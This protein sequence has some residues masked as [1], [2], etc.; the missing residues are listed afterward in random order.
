M[1]RKAVTTVGA[2]ALADG[3][4][5]EGSIGRG[6]SMADVTDRERF[7][8]EREKWRADFD[9]RGREVAVKEREQASSNWRSP[10]VVA[11]MAAT[12]AAGGNA[13]VAIVNG[14]QQVNLENSKAE[15]ARILEM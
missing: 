6:L 3:L 1:S 7:E 15:S 13:V 5:R 8:F 11:I 9:M 2:S 12:A 14:T 10:I 4:H